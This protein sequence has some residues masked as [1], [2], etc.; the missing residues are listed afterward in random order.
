MFLIAD[1]SGYTKFMRAHAMNVSHAKQ[2]VVRLIRALINEAKPPLNV[3]ELEGDAV[4]FYASGE[5]HERIADEVKRQIPRLFGAFRT[6]LDALVADNMCDCD[7]CM[8]AGDLMLKQ[9]V[10]Q[11]EAQ[12]EQIGRFEKLFGLDV[13][14]VHRLL[15]NSVPGN[16]YVLMTTSAYEVFHDF[17]GVEAE[18]G[19]EDVE[20]I[21]EVGTMLVYREPLE[22]TIRDSM[23]QLPIQPTEQKRRWYWKLVASTLLDMAR[24]RAIKGTFRNIPA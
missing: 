2:V 8:A 19:E 4:F 12:V 21:G 22:Q 6:E 15:K 17:F 10:H 9:V 24:I 14:L 16:E 7:A 5:D 11:G 18:P 1:I 20:G 23:A 3:A 13:I